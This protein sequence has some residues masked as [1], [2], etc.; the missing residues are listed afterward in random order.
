MSIKVQKYLL[1]MGKS[2]AYTAS[3]VLS[4]KFEFVNDFKNENQE[5]FKSAYSSIKDYRTTFSRIKKTITNNKIMDAARVGFDSVLYSVTSGDFYAKEKENEVV[6]KYGGNLMEGMDIDDEDFNWENEDLSM[7]DKVVATAIKKNS[8]ISTAITTEAI[9]KTGKAQMDVSRENTMLLYTQNERLMNKLDGGLNNI[10]GFLKQN[11]EQTAKVQNQ[12]NENLNKFMTNVDNN[13]VKLTKQMDELLEMQRNMYKPTKEEEKKRVGYDDIISRNGVI[14]IKE[15]AKMVKKNAFNTINEQSGNMLSMIFGDAMGGANMLAQFAATP[16][17][18]LM[19]AGA[20]K[21]LG[22]KFD[23]AAKELNTTLE[24]I[25]P[26]MMAKLNAASNKEDA[27][28]MKFI[29]KIFGVKDKSNESVNTDKYTKGA[30]PFDGITKRAITD[31]IPYYLRKMTSYLSGGEEMVYDYQ[32]GRWKTIRSVKQD[33][34]RT[35]HAARDNTS[36]TIV[37]TLESGIGRSLSSAFDTKENYDRYMTA[38]EALASRLQAVGDFGS[39]NESDL[40]G[41]EGEVYR[42]LKKVM[43]LNRNGKHG[44]EDRRFITTSSGKKISSGLGRSAISSFNSSLRSHKV[45]QN[46]SIKSMNEGDTIARIIAA[47]GLDTKDLK[48]YFGKDFVG[49]HGDIN[50]RKIQEMPMSQALVRAKDEYGVTLYQYLRDMGTSLRVIKGH[51]IYLGGIPQST[52]SG[53]VDLKE[54]LKDGDIKYDSQK[55]VK[56]S[57]KYYEDQATDKKIKES[58]SWK[59]SVQKRID[60]A[61]DKGK[62]YSVATTTDFK[63]NDKETGLARLISDSEADKTAKA[64]TEY[65]KAEAKKEKEKWNKLSE[66]FPREQVNKLKE[67]SA[68]FDKDKSLKENMQDVKGFTNQLYMFSKW[69]GNKVGKPGDAAADTILKVD[70]Y[71]QNLI[72]GEDLKESERKQS[73]FERMKSGFDEHMEKIK[74]KIGEGFDWIKKK[75]GDFFE[76]SGLKKLSEKIFGEVDSETGVR[77]GGV[78]GNFIG[79]VQK[80]LRKNGEDVWNYT[81]KQ[82][83]AAKKALGIKDREDNNSGTSDNPPSPHKPTTSERRE[84]LLSKLEEDAKSENQYIADIAREKISKIAAYRS[85][86]NAEKN[87]YQ[88][89]IG[90][91]DSQRENKKQELINTLQTKI[92]NQENAIEVEERKLSELRERLSAMP[93]KMSKYWSPEQQNEWRTNRH[94]LLKDIDNHKKTLK[95]IR[96]N[97][98]EN[99]K[100]LLKYTGSVTKI[101]HLAVGGVNKTGKP[102]QSVLSAG[103]YLNGSPIS[104]TGIY[105]IPKGGVVV[106]PAPASVRSKQAANERHFI[107]N[108]KRNAEANDKLEPISTNDNQQNQDKEAKKKEKLAAQKAEITKIANTDWTKLEDDK[109]RAEWLGNMASRGIIGGGLGL[110]AGGPILGAAIGAA[111]S[112]T[113]STSSF[114]NFLFGDATGEVDENGNLKRVDNGL[115]SK[116]LMDAVPSIKK[117][118][119]GGLIAGLLTP[120]GPLGGVLAGSALGFAKN[121][122]IFQGSLFGEG[123]ILSDENISK[124]KKGAKNMGIGAVIGAFTGP[125][126]LVGNAL[127]GA[128]AGYVT[129]TDKFKDAILGKKDNPDDPE[130]KRHGGVI[131]TLKKAV[132][133]LKSFG[134]TIVDG[135][136]DAIFGKKNGNDKREGGLFGLVRDKV[137]NPLADG[138]KSIV[139]ELQNTMVDLKFG[140]KKTWKKIQ[141]WMSGGNFFGTWGERTN[142]VAKGAIGIAKGGAK[143]ALSPFTAAAGAVKG[144]GNMFKRKRIRTGRADDMTARERLKARNSLKMSAMDDYSEFDERLSMMDNDSITALMDRLSYTVNDKEALRKEKNSVHDNL[145]AK[146]EDTLTS[147]EANKVIKL[148][149]DG[150]YSDAER[151]INISSFKGRKGSGVTQEERAD[152]IKLARKHKKDTGSLDDRFKKAEE[153]GKLN[154]KE[155][156]DTLGIDID[157]GD[158]QAVDNVLRMLRREKTHNEAGLTDEDLEYDRLREFWSNEKSPLKTVNEGVMSLVN[159]VDTIINEYK[160]GNEYDKLSDE[161]KAKYESKEDY[162]SKKTTEAK[163]SND[164]LNGGNNDSNKPANQKFSRIKSIQENPDTYSDTINKLATDALYIFDTRVMDEIKDPQK[165]KLDIDKW[166][167]E[168]P[169]KEDAKYVKLSREIIIAEFGTEYKFTVNYGCNTGKTSTVKISKNQEDS[170]TNCREAFANAYLDLYI[171]KDIKKKFPHMGLKEMIKKTIKMSAFCLVASAIIPGSGLVFLGLKALDSKFKIRE[172]VKK[173]NPIGKAKAG[174]KKVF[175]SHE[176]DSNSKTQ[177]RREKNYSE[178]AKKALE[179]AIANNDSKLNDIAMEKYKT[180][181]VNLDEDKKKVVNDEFMARYKDEKISRQIMGRGLIGGVKKI[182]QNAIDGVKSGAKK[183]AGTVKSGVKNA[184]S[185]ALDSHREKK[186]KK[187]EANNFIDNFIDKLEHSKLRKE[188]KDFEGKKDSKWAKIIKWLFI[189][190]IAAP[191]VVGFVKEK[192][193]PAIH[194]KIQPWLKKAGEKLIGKKNPQTGEYEGGLVSGIVNPIRGFFKDKFQTVHDWFHNEGKFNNEKSG[195]KGLLNNLKGVGTYII[196]LWKSGMSTMYNELVPKLVENFVVNLVPLTA[197]ILKGL[198]NGIK[199]LITGDKNY[200]G[201]QDMDNIGANTLGGSAGSTSQSI[202]NND[203]G[204]NNT[205]GGSISLPPPKAVALGW[206]TPMLVDSPDGMKV[207]KNLDGTET[208][209]NKYGESVSTQKIDDKEMMYYGTND[210]MQKL[211]MRRDGSD[212]KKYVRNNDGTYSPYAELQ[213]VYDSK[214]YGNE[215]YDEAIKNYEK[216]TAEANKDE[217]GY[218]NDDGLKSGTHRVAQTALAAIFSKNKTRSNNIKGAGNL[219]NLF[220]KGMSKLGKGISHAPLG[221]IVGRLT[222]LSGTGFRGI[223]KA[224]SVL[225]DMTSTGNDLFHILSDHIDTKRGL[226][227]AENVS[228]TAAAKNIDDIGANIAANVSREDGSLF[229]KF[230]NYFKGKRNVKIDNKLQSQIE[231]QAIKYVSKNK[232]Y[233]NALKEALENGMTKKEAKKIAQEA[234][235]K[236]I[237]QFKSTFSDAVQ[238][239]SSKK[240]AKKLAQQTLAETSDELIESV[241]ENSTKKAAKEVT[242]EAAEKGAKNIASTIIENTVQN[243]TKNVAKEVTEEGV[244][245]TVK[246]VTKEVVEDVTTDGK[247]IK[248]LTKF[249]KAFPEKI[250]GALTDLFKNKGFKAVV[251]EK[252][253]K[254]FTSSTGVKMLKTA[255]KTF[256]EEMAKECVEK[257]AKKAG[258]AAFKS[259]LSAVNTVPFAQLVSL[260]ISVVM[261]VVDFITG[262]NDAGNILQIANDKLTF[263][264]KLMASLIRGLQSLLSSLPGVGMIFTGIFLLLNEQVLATIVIKAFNLLVNF[265]TGEDADIMKRREESATEW[266]QFNQDNNTH[267]SFEQWN[268]RENAT[269]WTKFKGKVSSGGWSLL[270]KDQQIKEDLEAGAYKISAK[271]DIIE[272]IKSKLSDI[273]GYMWKT[274]KKKILKAKEVTRDQF[275]N[276]CVKVIDKIVILLNNVDDEKLEEVYDSA[277]HISGPIDWKLRGDDAFD[278]GWKNAKS[279]LNLPDDIDNTT[280]IKC[281]GGIASV[282][283]KSCGGAGLKWKIISII[284]SEFGDLFR[285]VDDEQMIKLI[286]EQ[287]KNI[288][289]VNED[290]NSAANID[291]SDLL[292]QPVDYG[293]D[294]EEVIATNA[295]ANNKL[296][297]MSGKQLEVYNKFKGGAKSILNK[298]LHPKDTLLAAKNNISNLI[299]KGIHAGA[300]ILNLLNPISLVDRIKSIIQDPT[301]ALSQAKSTISSFIGKGFGFIRNGLGRLRSNAEA[302]DGLSPLTNNPLFGMMG[303]FIGKFAS[304]AINS[305]TGGGFDKVEELFSNLKAKNKSTND[306]IDSLNLLPS[307]NKYWDIELDNKSPFLSGLFSFMESMSRVVKAPFALAAASMSSGL[308]AIAN[309]NSNSSSSSNSNNNG[310]NSGSNSGSNNTSSSGSKKKKGLFGNLFGRIAKAG[311]ALL[312]RGKSDEDN[313]DTG[314]GED[315]FH[316]YQRDYKGSYRTAGDT[317]NQTVADSGCGPAAAASLLRMYGKKGDM[318]NAVRYALN[319]KYKEVDG[320]TYP[321]YFND[322]LSKNGINTNSNANNEDVINSLVHNKPVILMGRDLNNSGR[323]P[324]GSKYSHYVVARGLDSNGNVIVE[325]SEDKNGSTRYSL[326]DTLRS[327]SVKITTGNGKYGRAKSSSVM[328]KYIYGIN[329]VVHAGV[330]SVINNAA[331]SITGSSGN[332]ISNNNNNNSTSTGTNGTCGDL[333]KDSDVKTTCGYTADELKAAINSIN[334][335]CSAEQFPEPAIALEKS[336]G[337]N[338]LFSIAVAVQEHGWNGHVGVN[339][340]GGNYGNWNVFNKEGTPNSSNGR[341]Q[342]FDSLED[343][344][345]AFGE[346]I[347]D[348]SLYYKAGLTTPAKIGNVYC[349]PNAA[350][351]SGYSPWGESVCEVASLIASKISGKGRGK[352]NKVIRP[353]MTSKFMNNVNSVIGYYANQVIDRGD[354]GD[355]Q[356]NSQTNNNS[357]S[358]S[359][360]V[361]IDASTTIICGDSITWGLGTTSLGDRAMGVVS[362]TTDKN[363][364]GSG[365]QTYETQFKAKSNIIEGASDAIFFWGMNEVFTSQSTDDYFN[366]YQDS[367]NTILGY[368]GRSTS[369]TNIYILPVI[370]VPDGSG[371]GGIYNASAVEAFNTKYVKPFAQNKGYTLVDIYEDTKQV[372]HGAGDVHPSDYQKLYEIIKAHMSG[373]SS[374]T[375]EDASGSGRGRKTVDRVSEL[376]NEAAR[377]SHLNNGSS[378]G[379]GRGTTSNRTSSPKLTSSNGKRIRRNNSKYLRKYGRGIWGRDGEEETTTTTTSTEDGTTTDDATTED[380]TTTETTTDT[381][382]NKQKTSD[383]TGLIS[384]FGK[385]SKALTKGIFGDFYDALYGSEVEEGGVNSNG[386]VGSGDAAKMLGKS[387]T[388]SRNN[389]KGD[390]SMTIA[391]T[392]DEVELYDMLTGECGLNAAVACGIIGNWEEEC[393]INSIQA[394]AIKGKIYYGG[395]IMQWTP[396]DKHVTWANSNGFS[397]NPWSWEAN[398]AH[399]KA[400][401]LAGNGNWSNCTSADPSLSSKGFK[402]CGSFEEFKNL[403][404]AEDAAVNYERAFEVSFNWNGRTSEAATLPANKYYDN[405]R[406]LAG[407]ILYELIVNGKCDG[408][409]NSGSGRGKNEI[410]YYPKEVS[411]AEM[412]IGRKTKSNKK[413]GRG[414]WGRDGEE[415]FIGPKKPDDFNNTTNNSQEVYGPQPLPD[416][417]KNNENP[418]DEATTD[419]TSNNTKSSSKVGAKSL[420]SKLGKYAKAGI[421]GVFGNFYDALYGSEAEEGDV[422]ESSGSYTDGSGPIY[423]AAMVFEAMGKANPTFGY[424]YCGNRTFDITCRDGKKLEKVRPDCSG[425]MTAVA[426]YMGYYSNA[427]GTSWTDTY[428]GHGYNV[429]GCWSNGFLD[430]DGNKSPDWEYIDFDPNDKR[431]G[432]MIIRSDGGHIDMYVF[433]DSSGNSR[434]FNAGSGGA[435][436]DGHCDSPGHGIENSYKF[437]Q[438]YLDNGNS[439]P[440]NDGSIGAWTIQ[441]SE[442]AKVIRYVGGGSGRGKGS[443]ENK[444]SNNSVSNI[445]KYRAIPDNNSP[446][447]IPM[448]VQQKIGRMNHS[449]FGMGVLKSLDEVQQHTKNRILFGNNTTSNSQSSNNISHAN[450]SSNYI[451]TSSIS[452]NNQQIDLNQLITLIN[453]IAN[454]SDKMD[455]VLQLL[456]T[457]AVNTE[458]TSTAVSNNNKQTTGSKNGLSALRSALDNNSSGVDIAKAVY[459]IA[460]S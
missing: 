278:D 344:F 84:S 215:G 369:D 359:A 447:G 396:P 219:F 144:V 305:I 140:I 248:N 413:Y 455:A 422:D 358:G 50:D 54:I 351:N 357:S 230:K 400:E 80:G 300:D 330:L 148:L 3:D 213:N 409:S 329:S 296:S 212:T 89:D 57:M 198:V 402:A 25:I 187:K 247:S 261:V 268:N 220:G 456:G 217:V 297:K 403:T 119:L 436:P 244:E 48:T 421:K 310:S 161:D 43:G 229:S 431:P 423:A 267:L 394:T 158:E 379:R 324:Y 350:E 108:L 360:N 404:S 96:K 65:Y 61:R 301:A 336:K 200:T 124:L 27:G 153:V 308:S 39:I 347:M 371:Y 53:P 386:S 312:G 99:K 279:Y 406:A 13:V 437:G 354:G 388:L 376:Q 275:M 449:G 384:L 182:G 416:D 259:V 92:S 253:V 298:L 370:W 149:K 284:I 37:K 397:D 281:V 442:G 11:G 228:E 188:K 362:G 157:L 392:Q 112:L 280:T 260:A 71:L 368:G 240:A 314:Y 338:A 460:K 208:A 125:F 270:G 440:P 150:K 173:F 98:E 186:A 163:E 458:N 216:S 242:E 19:S 26:A 172:K 321:Q 7:G 258:K 245:K 395:G 285:A 411:K 405:N 390:L 49:S 28:I 2:V 380:G 452:N 143:V 276:T 95:N 438:Y 334:P 83:E 175:G 20:N 1:N 40:R 145:R 323:T 399:A 142:K 209:T 51:S 408:D 6:M 94:Q 427:A 233:K 346:L 146:L 271:S 290:Y 364:T 407:K 445:E 176:I 331:N 168:N 274:R 45:S 38:I 193:M 232:I 429:S 128:T 374:T 35:V 192:L 34:D 184:I 318:N 123:G 250:V 154:S 313:S 87:R 77:H 166:K 42:A 434:G 46:S 114:A 383:A 303:N 32:T 113:K 107:S 121:S 238:K 343:A 201:Q 210:S 194:E 141:N 78:F 195:F 102:F 152:L 110:L 59:E 428:H 190:G 387:L 56:Y 439:L 191:I 174:L 21:M 132:N 430:K 147:T 418:S 74:E 90:S 316:I 189:G 221:G 111:S 101:K 218:Y 249:L 205:V 286:E 239:G 131:G 85:K 100:Q 17:R 115:I 293:T 398:K 130:S 31:V 60:K 203:Y 340:D 70:Y 333:T 122:E 315:P 183:L 58:K 367:I 18:S 30:I 162:I 116:E 69:A 433:T 105:T 255:A 137:I 97:L 295:N 353:A 10:M 93:S 178:K 412:I 237:T 104:Q 325:D 426:M 179:K 24:G 450:G 52:N 453:V 448:S 14:N 127:L 283:V 289:D 9:V 185:G 117:F 68:K 385:Y 288:A 75:A 319:N 307:D 365:G 44:E 55:D 106:N 287:N 352:L 309:D 457:I 401:I 335:G 317:E 63:S 169:D 348:S 103:E 266:Q 180:D 375:T 126:G 41:T 36:S 263:T 415:E 443:S 211:Y 165:I 389:G 342:D 264:D 207:I 311:R 66:I 227:F 12:M 81:K 454:N 292:Q 419:E 82:A 136:T 231:S 223:G 420:I 167:L 291:A 86:Q 277:C 129:S 273:I 64:E 23:N 181:Y 326:A 294:A 171:P 361:D 320:G 164:K 109:Q 47:E 199:A 226:N 417:L 222:Q 265:V 451:S 91:T 15:Y 302:N 373:D 425:M 339:T 72:Y 8:K 363:C 88:N 76:K 246:N 391:I 197:G 256:T 393:G 62:T 254:K 355:N 120:I 225:G 159:K 202:S 4:E 381:T 252:I 435:F 327:S 366:Q 446:R 341:W 257:G 224:T 337:V 33:Y 299:G 5:V 332:K 269:G 135:V 243:G 372:P 133:P 134:K 214:L 22:K 241:V 304:K 441:D 177:K 151:L 414:V 349:P 251:G 459:Q 79:G 272:D 160:L 345:T 196:D 29:G 424:C 234:E 382:E 322:Y 16:F 432:D 155:I 67:I 410:P 377:T 235:E 262:W 73:L 204:F 444:K 356:S 170:Y 138:T 206:D 118:G 156:K 306:S 282:L 378:Y 139:K 236:A 328:E